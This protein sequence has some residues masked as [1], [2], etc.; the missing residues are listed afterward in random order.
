MLSDGAEGAARALPEPTASRIEAVVHQI[1]MQRLDDG[2][3]D[4]CDIT[5]KEI[6]RVE[7]SLSKSLCSIY[8]GRVPYP[9]QRKAEAEAPAEER[10]KVNV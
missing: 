1:V 8:H 10:E 9:K 2:Q 3:F 5:L 6:R 7:D 4:D